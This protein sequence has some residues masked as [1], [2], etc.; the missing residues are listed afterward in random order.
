MLLLNMD[1]AFFVCEN[2]KFEIHIHKHNL[3]KTC[4]L[5]FWIFSSFPVLAFFLITFWQGP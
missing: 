1:H 4:S 3:C 2:S 5:F